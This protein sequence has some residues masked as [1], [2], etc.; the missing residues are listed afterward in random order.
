MI[1][2]QDLTKSVV[3]SAA[4]SGF[5]PEDWFAVQQLIARYSDAVDRHDPEQMRSCWT[6]DSVF[7]PPVGDEARGRDGIVEHELKLWK[8][9][10]DTGIR[11]R[12]HITCVLLTTTA[13]A[14]VTAR[15][16]MA[17]SNMSDDGGYI[18]STYLA[19]DVIVKEGDEWRF[20]FRAL[21]HD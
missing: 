15:V 13:A 7:I 2:K 14:R 1:D 4:D 9:A 21:V 20:A 3:D 5:T 18:E 6:E 10:E 17:S 11:R 12:H 8:R 19:E 16:G